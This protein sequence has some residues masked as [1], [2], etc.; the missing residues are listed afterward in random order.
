MY[1]YGHFNATYW[2]KLD[3]NKSTIIM[4]VYLLVS[5]FLLPQDCSEKQEL[6]SHQSEHILDP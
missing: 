1:K 4:P 6:W 3:T 5:I 2:L